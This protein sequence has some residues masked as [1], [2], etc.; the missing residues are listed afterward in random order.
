MYHSFL[1]RLTKKS[2]KR[3]NGLTVFLICTAALFHALPPRLILPFSK[4]NNKVLRSDCNMPDCFNG[5]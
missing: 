4:K 2:Q 3:K 5:F 1:C